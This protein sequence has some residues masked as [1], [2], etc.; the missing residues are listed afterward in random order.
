M[1]MYMS[2]PVAPGVRV[3]QNLAGGRRRG[4]GGGGVGAL[5]GLVLLSMLAL[6][7]LIAYWWLFAI[8]AGVALAVWS[9]ARYGGK[10]IAA[11]EAEKAAL[12]EAAVP[13]LDTAGCCTVCG[14]PGEVHVSADG[15]VIPVEQ[16]HAVVS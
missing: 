5:V 2:V 7:V 12:A 4:G 8:L 15:V 11:E 1:R 3:S 13:R 16:W 9:I 6:A 14:A 10:L